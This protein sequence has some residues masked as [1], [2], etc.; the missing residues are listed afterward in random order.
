MT[1]SF[2]IVKIKQNHIQEK[3]YVFIQLTINTVVRE[4]I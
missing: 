2:Y 4:N 3:T 1:T